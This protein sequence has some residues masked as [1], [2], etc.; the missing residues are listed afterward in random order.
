MTL[1]AEET[2]MVEAVRDQGRKLMATLAVVV[3][4]LVRVRPGAPITLQMTTLPPTRER[5]GS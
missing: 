1:N 5:N 4:G 3:N 2:A